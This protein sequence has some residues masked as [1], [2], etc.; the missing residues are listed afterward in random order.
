MKTTKRKTETCSSTQET[1]TVKDARNS[2]N[3]VSSEMD[4]KVPSRPKSASTRIRI[5][6]LACSNTGLLVFFTVYLCLGAFIFQLLE[7][8]EELKLCEEG[9][10]KFE[11]KLE[12]LNEHLFN[13]VLYNVSDIYFD[14]ISNTRVNSPASASDTSRAIGRMLVEFRDFSLHIKSSYRYTGQDCMQN[15]NWNYIKALE[16]CMT[17]VTT[18]G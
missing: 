8:H 16:F 9:K 10:G 18:I 4:R 12:N 11:Q 6:K 1:D 2:G 13:Y 3:I 14:L 5:S 15:S 7:K 17:A